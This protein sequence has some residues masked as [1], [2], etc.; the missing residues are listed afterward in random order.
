MNTPITAQLPETI[1]TSL[2]GPIDQAMLQR[3]FNSC[4]IAINGGVK[5]IHC[6]FQTN[7]GLIADG[8][9]LYN[10]FQSLPI[11]FH[12]YNIGS[13]QS[14]GVI[15]FLGA[16]HRYASAN[17]TFMIHKSRYNPQTPTD[18]DRA[19]GMADALK[20]EDTRTRGILKSELN[21]S[22]VELERHLITEVPFDAPAALKYGL[23][24]EIR[25]F[26]L[27]PSTMLSNI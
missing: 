3:V 20:I 10:Y 26:D 25:D 2:A 23:I 1:Y 6:I 11:D 16:D 22:T 13:V 7:G 27:P 12:M 4:A 19:T 21:I 18:A 24:S 8:I 14:I 9:A 17:A 5:N 15:A